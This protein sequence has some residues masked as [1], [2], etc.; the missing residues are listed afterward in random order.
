M[1]RLEVDAGCLPCLLST[2]T[3][4]VLLSQALSTSASLAS[5]IL[6]EFPSPFYMWE[7]QEAAMPAWLF[8]GLWKHE[9]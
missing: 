7:L 4:A 3:E 5:H 1:W 2:V 6:W 9:L 8:S